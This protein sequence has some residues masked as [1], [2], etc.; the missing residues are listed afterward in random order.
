MLVWSVCTLKRATRK[1]KR[2]VSA[3]YLQSVPEWGAHHGVDPPIRSGAPLV[4]SVPL[5][6]STACLSCRPAHL[7]TRV[8]CLRWNHA[9]FLRPSRPRLRTTLHP[10]LYKKPS[11]FP[12]LWLAMLMVGVRASSRSLDCYIPSNLE[13]TGGVT[14]GIGA[15]KAGDWDPRPRGAVS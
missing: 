1:R 7:E 14:D 10:R 8:L 15:E 6:P 12:L 13:M 2:K 11:V 5:L 4:D 3:R 9:Y